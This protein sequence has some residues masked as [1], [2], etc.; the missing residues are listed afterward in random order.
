MLFLTLSNADIKFAKKELTWRSYTTAEALPTIKRVELI[1]KKEFAKAA[2][3]ENVEAFV[4]HVTSFSLYL[5][6]TMSIHPARKAQIALLLTEKVTI[7]DNQIKPT[8]N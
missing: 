5:G 7:P 2:L 3:N 6:P 1:D 4:V 8:R